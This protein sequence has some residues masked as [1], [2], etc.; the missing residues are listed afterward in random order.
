MLYLLISELNPLLTKK[1]QDKSRFL[2]PKIEH[3]TVKDHLDTRF[4]FD[5][6]APLS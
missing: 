3:K 2:Q 5:K 6:Q 4:C 1:I